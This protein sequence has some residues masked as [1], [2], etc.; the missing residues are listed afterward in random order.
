MHYL[1]VLILQCNSKKA[2]QVLAHLV[3]FSALEGFHNR[4]N[5]ITRRRLR[6]VA[7]RTSDIQA[8]LCTATEE[9]G[10]PRRRIKSC[11]LGEHRHHERSRQY[12]IR[13]SVTWFDSAAVHWTKWEYYHWWHCLDCEEGRWTRSLFASIM[14]SKAT[15]SFNHKVFGVT[16]EVLQSFFD[17]HWRV[18]N[19]LKTQEIC[20]IMTSC[21]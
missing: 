8:F 1:F 9:Q 17:D 6:V 11:C 12:V 10:Y 5:D 19:N 18:W 4:F 7:P 21:G 2:I 14:S 15:N 13:K 20:Q 16:S 3:C